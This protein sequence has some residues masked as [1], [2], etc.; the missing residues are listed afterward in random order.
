VPQKYYGYS[1]GPIAASIAAFDN[2]VIVYLIGFDMGPVHTKFNNVYADT[3]FYK[4]SSA[5]PTFTGNW[6]RQ[7]TT[8]MKDFPKIAFVRVAGGTTTPIKEFD[9]VKN[10]QTMDIADFLN[11]I[12][13]TKEL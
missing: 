7:L 8:V 12:N 11:R 3:E 13:N 9:T 1:S 6:V 2:A 4:K 5:P 10:F